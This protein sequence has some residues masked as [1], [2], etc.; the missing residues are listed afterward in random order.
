MGALIF[1]KKN[2]RALKG[3]KE[4][5]WGGGGVSLIK[6]RNFNLPYFGVMFEGDP[7][8][9]LNY[10]KGVPETHECYLVGIWELFLQQKH[11]PPPT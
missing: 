7:E 2:I 9:F 8:L 3:Q 11:S 6:A 5:F 1:L 10:K 4:G